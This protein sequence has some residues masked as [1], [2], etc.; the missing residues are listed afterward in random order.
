M[1]SRK[2]VQ[3]DLP[4]IEDLS[5]IAVQNQKR[6]LKS[7]PQYTFTWIDI[8]IIFVSMCTFVADIVTGMITCNLYLYTVCCIGLQVNKNLNFLKPKI[9]SHYYCFHQSAIIYY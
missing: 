2:N 9:C 3:L 4:I 7:S 5:Y 6:R 1:A 8:V